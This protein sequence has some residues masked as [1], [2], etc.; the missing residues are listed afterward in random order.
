MRTLVIHPEDP[1]TEFL[2]GVYSGLKDV[3]VIRSDIGLLKTACA[4]EDADRVIMLGH[5]TPQGLLSV[6]KFHSSNG[7][8]ISDGDAFR[9]TSPENIYIWCNADQYVQRNRL[10]STLYSGMFVSEMGEAIMMGLDVVP[11]QVN[12]S[13]HLFAKALK[14][15]LRYNNM[16]LVKDI[17]PIA[18]SNPVIRYN[19]ERLYSS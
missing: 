16:T 12:R 14:S 18:H 1:S 6:G 15:A 2:M 5:G 17:Y 19:A 7:L 4:I 13:N 8:V 3:E 10:P 11:S 9:L